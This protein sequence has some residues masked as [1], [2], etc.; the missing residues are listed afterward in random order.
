MPY[1]AFLF[2]LDHSF[3]LAA[4]TRGRNTRSTYKIESRKSVSLVQIIDDSDTV[5][6]CDLCFRCRGNL[7]RL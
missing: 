2:L 1:V 7:E 4:L 3:A 5:L 6:Q